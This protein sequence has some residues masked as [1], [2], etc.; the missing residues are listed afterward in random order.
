L[1]TKFFF[2]KLIHQIGPCFFRKLIHQIDPCRKRGAKRKLE[3]DEDKPLETASKR[4][5]RKKEAAA[6][7]GEVERSAATPEKVG[8]RSSQDIPSQDI[9]SQDIPSQDIPSHD[10]SSHDISSQD[11]PSQDIPT[12]VAPSK[13]NSQLLSSPQVRF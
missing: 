5:R 2:R 4:G 12:S 13:I 8:D 7:N 3:A 11:I 9:P 10:I 6:T 1:P